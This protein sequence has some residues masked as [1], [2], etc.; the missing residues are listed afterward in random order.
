VEKVLIVLAWGALV[1]WAVRPVPGK[2]IPV[3]RRWARVYLSGRQALAIGGAL[4]AFSLAMV[5]LAWARRD[6]DLVLVGVCLGW[7]GALLV[8]HGRRI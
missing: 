3:G 4:L 1:A 8:L 2:G 5:G 7:L 6:A